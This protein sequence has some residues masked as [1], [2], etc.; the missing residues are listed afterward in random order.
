M[1]ADELQKLTELHRQGA[2][3]DY[4]FTEAKHKLLSN[5][6]GQVPAT[7]LPVEDSSYR[8]FGPSSSM[9]F[10]LLALLATLFVKGGFLIAALTNRKLVE[11][12]PQLDEKTWL[13]V[14]ILD[15]FLMPLLC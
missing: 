1:I 12:A 8:R 11:G 13:P 6:N 15:A 10:A 9:V 2:L 5:S 4:E 14:L 3:T 7:V